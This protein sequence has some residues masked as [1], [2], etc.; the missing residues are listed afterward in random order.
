MR[1]QI[2]TPKFLTLQQINIRKFKRKKEKKKKEIKK[3]SL[4]IY[5]GSNPVYPFPL[6]QFQDLKK[7]TKT[8][9]QKAQKQ[10]KKKTL[11]NPHP[12]REKK[13]EEKLTNLDK[14]EAN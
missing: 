8:T 12:P 14:R 9:Q 10:T 1:V 7:K 13:T 6:F 5:I 2:Q 3:R 11:I 4:V